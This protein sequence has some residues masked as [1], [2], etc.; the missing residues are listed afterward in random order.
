MKRVFALALLAASCSI[1]AQDFPDGTVDVYFQP[2]SSDGK[3]DGCSLVFT[4]LVRDYATQRGAQVIVNGS[5][6]IRKLQGDNLFF[7]GKL[8]TR[9]FSSQN[10]WQAPAHFFFST[11]NR[12]TAGVAKIAE[13]D[14]PGYKLLLAP[15]GTELIKLLGEMGESGQFTAGFNRRDGGQDVTT[16]IKLNVAL[17]KGPNGNAGTV[18]SEET[19]RDFFGC[20]SKLVR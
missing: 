1:Q 8:G 20:L 2:V 15:M 9:L 19:P 12:S 7:S 14:T 5:V 17:R 16:I 13:S 3:L 4:S 11:A 6:A 18:I 10:Q